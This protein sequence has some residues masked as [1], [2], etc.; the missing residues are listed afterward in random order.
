[1]LRL[2]ARDQAACAGKPLLF[3]E[4][5]RQGADLAQFQRAGPA[6]AV[7]GPIHVCPHRRPAQANAA[8]RGLRHGRPRD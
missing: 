8:A 4:P 6:V 7:P 3:P 5:G 1:M 2:A